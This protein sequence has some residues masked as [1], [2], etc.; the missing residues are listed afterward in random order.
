[1]KTSNLYTTI[2]QARL[3]NALG[4]ILNDHHAPILLPTEADEKKPAK[5]KAPDNIRA[6][7]YFRRAA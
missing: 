5:K 1:M 3:S 6:P 4:S 2:R 7:I